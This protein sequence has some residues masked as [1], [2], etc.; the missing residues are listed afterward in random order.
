MKLPP[1]FWSTF[2]YQGLFHSLLDVNVALD[3]NQTSPSVAETMSE[4]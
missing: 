4:F 1:C 3:G 2:V